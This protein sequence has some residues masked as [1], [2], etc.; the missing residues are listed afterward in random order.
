MNRFLVFFV[1]FVRIECINL[2]WWGVKLLDDGLGFEVVICLMI[3]LRVDFLLGLIKLVMGRS[4]LVKLFI[5]KGFDLLVMYFCIVVLM[6]LG[7]CWVRVLIV[8]MFFLILK[9]ML[10]MGWFCRF[11][12][13]LGLF[14][15]IGMFSFLRSFLLLMFDS[16]RSFGDLKILVVRMIFFLVVRVI[17]LLF[18]WIWILMV[19]G[20]V[21]VVLNKIFFVRVLVI[22]W[23]LGWDLVG[24][25]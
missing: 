25:K 16:F 20:F 10:E 8:L 24:L 5:V 14:I 21:L 22:I 6:V 19:F 9:F 7:F 13:I 4:D 2:V 12:F 15:I 18:F 23:R 1:W 17:V 3:W 11:L